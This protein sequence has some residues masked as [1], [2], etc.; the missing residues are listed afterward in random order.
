MESAYVI[1]MATLMVRVVLGI[2]FFAQGY[3]KI[4][5]IGINAVVDAA[6]TVDMHKV[7]GKGL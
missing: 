1:P 2:L 3:D 7:L 6:S 5:K 4:F